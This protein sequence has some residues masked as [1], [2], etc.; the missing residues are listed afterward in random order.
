MCAFFEECLQDEQRQN[1]YDLFIWKVSV[2]LH[3]N[4]HILDFLRLILI[5]LKPPY[6]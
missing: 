2:S 6:T 5:L 4:L 1:S 3:K